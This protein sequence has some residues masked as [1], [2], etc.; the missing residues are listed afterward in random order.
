MS[1]R[2]SRAEARHLLAVTTGLQSYILVLFHPDWSHWL[3]PSIVILSLG[4][5]ASLVA[6]A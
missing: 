3:A 5:A 1:R 4:A 6:R 2:V